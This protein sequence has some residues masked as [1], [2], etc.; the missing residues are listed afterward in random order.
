MTAWS[1]A[2]LPS[3]LWWPMAVSMASDNP[4]SGSIRIT[5]MQAGHLP[6]VMGIEEDSTNPRGSEGLW[7]R[8]LTA[9]PSRNLVAVLNR[10]GVEEVVGFVNFWNVAGEV[11]LNGIAVKRTCRRMGIGGRLLQTMAEM[12]ALERATAAT[13][14]VRASNT[15]AINLY[16]KKCICDKR[17]TPRVLRRR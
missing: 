11:Q 5:A 6:E 14:E 1:S 2:S 7:A 8:E 3:L 17:E 16:E 13:L 10:G 9:A 12:A 4:D 15:A